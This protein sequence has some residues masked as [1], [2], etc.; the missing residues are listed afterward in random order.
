MSGPTWRTLTA[1]MGANQVSIHGSLRGSNGFLNDLGGFWWVVMV[2]LVVCVCV[3]FHFPC[4]KT[5][6]APRPGRGQHLDS[7]HSSWRYP[8]FLRKKSL[9]SSYWSLPFSLWIMHD[10]DEVCASECGRLPLPRKKTRWSHVKSGFPRCPGTSFFSSRQTP[11][12]N[13]I[14]SCW[15]PRCGES[16]GIH[17]DRWDPDFIHPHRRAVII[18]NHII[19]YVHIYSRMQ[20]NLL[21][22]KHGNRQSSIFRW[23]S[24]STTIDLFFP[25]E[26]PYDIMTIDHWHLSHCHDWPGPSTAGAADSQALG[27]PVAMRFECHGP[28]GAVTW[29]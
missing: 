3:S 13:W 16:N 9:R 2:M 12:S 7:F 4:T 8:F 14:T 21:V 27:S 28:A 23:F 11:L 20:Q 18:Y 1:L 17:M 10:Y 29:R 15:V 22:V 19:I 24:H 6:I 5:T 25:Q 26:P